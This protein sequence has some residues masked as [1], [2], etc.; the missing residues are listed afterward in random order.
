M[1]EVAVGRSPVVKLGVA[2]LDGWLKKMEGNEE[3]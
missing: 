3:R 2:G 1:G